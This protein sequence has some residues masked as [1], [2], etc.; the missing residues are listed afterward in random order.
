[1]MYRR[2]RS[3]FA[4]AIALS[5][6]GVVLMLG[7]AYGARTSAQLSNTTHT[8][9]VMQASYLAEAGAQ[10]GRNNANTFRLP[11]QRT[12]DFET[13]TAVVAITQGAQGTKV[14]R[15]TGSTPRA[16]CT[17]TVVLDDTMWDMERTTRV[18]RWTEVVQ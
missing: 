2:R 14:V 3:G 18:V 11:Y 16:R 8:V 1:M 7:L 17:V 13:G 5:M 9:Q 6:V 15:S 12:L 4:L 10:Y